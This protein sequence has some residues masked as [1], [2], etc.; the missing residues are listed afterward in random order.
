MMRTR[1]LWFG[2]GF[3][4]AGAAIAQFVWRDLLTDRH[5]LS[6]EV[7]HKFDALEAR[8]SMLESLKFRKA[9]STQVA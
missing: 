5:S 3:T 8:I 7:N 9:E 1:L 4:V 2:F 6:S